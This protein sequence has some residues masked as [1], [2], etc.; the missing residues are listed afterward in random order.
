MCPHGE[1]INWESSV[2]RTGPKA[3]HECAV[4]TLHHDVTSCY[5]H[6]IQGE[7]A[8]LSWGAGFPG[9]TLRFVSNSPK[10]ALIH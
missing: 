7:D 10:R 4:L 9:A 8:I 3:G 2:G 1:F 6:L 5:P